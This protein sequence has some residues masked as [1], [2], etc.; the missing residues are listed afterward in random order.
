MGD[1]QPAV[2]AYH[3]QPLTV[4]SPRLEMHPVLH[5]GN[6]GLSERSKNR[7]AVMQVFIQKQGVLFKLQSV[8]IPSE[9]PLLF[10]GLTACILLRVH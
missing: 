10:P 6:S 5:E 2:V 7:L 1:Q 4:W 9:L 8:L 3:W